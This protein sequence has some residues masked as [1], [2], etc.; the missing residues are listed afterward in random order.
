[1]RTDERKIDE[2]VYRDLGIRRDRQRLPEEPGIKI[3]I[4]NFRRGDSHVVMLEIEVPPG[5]DRRKVAS[6]FLKYKD[7]ILRRNQDTT[8]TCGVEYVPDQAQMLASTNPAVKKN[9]LGFQTGEA[10][11]EAA[12]LIDEGRTADAVRAIDERMVVLGIAAREWSDRDLDRDGRL[13]EQYKQVLVRLAANPGG[14]GGELGDYLKK[15][16]TYNGSQMLR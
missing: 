1:V 9:L 4:P 10:L 3:L 11:T 8:A 15:S 14:G 16:L 13:L 7:L 5:S 2:Q 6:V 12:R